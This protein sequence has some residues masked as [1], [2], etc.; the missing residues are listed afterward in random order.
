M[1]KDE[2]VKEGTCVYCSE[3]CPSYL[4]FE[5]T[6]RQRVYIQNKETFSNMRRCRKQTGDGNGTMEFRFHLRSESRFFLSYRPRSMPPFLQIL[7]TLYQTGILVP[8][9]I[10]IMHD[11]GNY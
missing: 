9:L 2:E 5:S 3:V 6:T 4:S 10:F 8:S 1:K 7:N 11:K